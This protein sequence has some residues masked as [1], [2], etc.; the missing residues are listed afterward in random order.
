MVVAFQIAVAT[1]LVMGAGL[2]LRTVWSL[3]SIDVGFNADNLLLFEINPPASRYSAGKDVLLHQRIE[4]RI[5][6]M[7]GIQSVTL[8]ALPYIAD[9]LSNSDFVPEGEVFDPQKAQA[10]DFNA[11]GNH[12]FETMEIPIAAGRGFNAEDT[13]TSR[14][15]GMINQSLARKRFP[16][17]NPVGRRF[18]ADRE[19]NAPWI[20]IVGVCRD[21][22]Y[23]NLR[24]QP[25]PQFF[26]PYVQQTRVGGMVYQV[27]TRLRSGDLMPQLRTAVEQI[28]P[29]LPII[30]VR[31]QREQINANA[32]IERAFAALTSG[33]AVL[34]LAF[35]AVGVYG[36]MAYS[37]AQRR[38]EI[39]I[40][41]ALGASRWRVSRMILRE[42]SWI[43]LAG[44][45]AGL[46]TTLLLTR[47]VQSMLYG[48]EP[49]DPMTL[50]LSLFVLLAI[51]LGA[52]WIPAQRA[53]SIDPMHALRHE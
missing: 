47:A 1:V 35:A 10:E 33:F 23:M 11:V 5:A 39:G 8:G 30:N 26:L 31:T 16:N 44:T 18:K 40:R 4:D 37:V 3:N 49:Y 32:S 41:V 46:G 7:P 45:L 12:F 15:V 29:D 17:T 2:F 20:E 24:D 50:C 51:A 19:A 34:A 22:H 25:P 42:S 27:R 28:D 9:N 36:V 48:I 6:A 53:A 14:K 21:T 13:A 38:N 52:S 43:A